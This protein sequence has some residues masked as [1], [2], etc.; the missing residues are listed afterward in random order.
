VSKNFFTAIVVL[1]V[2]LC[3]Q[4]KFVE[5]SVP[6][7]VRVQPNQILMGTFFNGSTISVSGEIPA[8]AEV[9]IRVTGHPEDNKI[10]I[11]GQ[12]L[13]ILWM[14]L[15]TAEFHKTPSV[16]LLYP[17]RALNELLQA[18]QQP[19]QDLGLGI[20]SVRKQVNIV[21][22]SEDKDMLFQE[23]VKLKQKAGLY[24]ILKDAIHYKEQNLGMKS[25]SGTLKLPS[26]LPQGTYKLEVY[27]IKDGSIAGSIAE[28]IE[29][30]EVGVPALI[31]T[32]AFN[33]GTLYGILAVLV[34]VIAGL[35][36]GIMFKGEKGAH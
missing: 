32:L 31:S 27:A 30:E 16:F 7:Q 20:E 15:G 9:L 11:K 34:A 10:K 13:G 26:D 22:E 14:N 25:F 19:W 12:A 4:P 29:A 3:G 5:A 36:T 23:F 35:L 17:S 1:W 6:L 24:G 2:L 28:D 8:D 18:S 21:S 33:H